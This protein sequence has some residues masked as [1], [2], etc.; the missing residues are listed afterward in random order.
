MGDPMS[1]STLYFL[2]L[3]RCLHVVLVFTILF[4][5]QISQ[6][7][8][9]RKIEKLIEN[10]AVSTKEGFDNVDDKFNKID[11]KFNKIDGKFNKI[12]N[13]FNKIDDKFL[14]LTARM[15]E[16]FLSIHQELKEIRQQINF[17]NSDISRLEKKINVALKTEKEDTRIL[18]IDMEEIKSKI[19][20]LESQLI[21]LKKNK[22]TSI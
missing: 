22:K 19:S 14:S 21:F 2:P 3:T 13:K 4:F 7:I 1:N 5:S 9:S 18:F 16:G 6:A 20:K 15:E 12:D 8:E 10:L 17:I 11:D